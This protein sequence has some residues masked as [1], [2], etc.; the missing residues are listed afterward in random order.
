VSVVVSARF[1]ADRLVVMVKC[2]VSVLC[3]VEQNGQFYWRLHTEGCRV[4]AGGAGRWADEGGFS[5]ASTAGVRSSYV[6]MRMP[7]AVPGSVAVVAAGLLSQQSLEVVVQWTVGLQRVT[8]GVKAYTWHFFLQSLL[9]TASKGG[10]S[11]AASCS[12]ARGGVCAGCRQWPVEQ[13]VFCV[14]RVPR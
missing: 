6:A 7:W 5:E 9:L 13:R 2:A 12:C 8:A 1:A 14:K 4:P 11:P 3:V 10:F